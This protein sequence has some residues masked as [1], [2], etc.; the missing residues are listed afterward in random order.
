[1]D[2]N[3]LLETEEGEKPLTGLSSAAAFAEFSARLRVSAIVCPRGNSS[4]W[5]K[6][7]V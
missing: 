2:V 1:M 5:M 3:R 4:C 6:A 7:G